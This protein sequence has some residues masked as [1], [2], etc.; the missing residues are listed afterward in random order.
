M[1]DNHPADFRWL[2]VDDY[3]KALINIGVIIVL[4]GKILQFKMDRYFYP[5]AV[6]AVVFADR[7]IDGINAI[8]IG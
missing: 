3:K 5:Y 6:V 2:V 4:E 1:F 7:V 8:T